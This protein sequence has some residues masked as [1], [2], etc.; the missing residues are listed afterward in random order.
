MGNRQD[1]QDFRQDQYEIFALQFCPNFIWVNLVTNLVN[2]V[3][4]LI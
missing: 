4:L 2:P 3:L 1:S